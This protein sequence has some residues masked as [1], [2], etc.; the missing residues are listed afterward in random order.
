MSISIRTLKDEARFRSDRISL[1]LFNS[2]VEYK[3]IIAWALFYFYCRLSSQV[4]SREQPHS[5]HQTGFSFLAPLDS[6]LTHSGLADV[7]G[8]LDP[9]LVD[10][11]T[12]SASLSRD[13]HP[14]VASFIYD[15][16]SFW[17]Q[18]IES[19]FRSHFCCY[20][21]HV[22]RTYPLEHSDPASSFSWH[23]DEDPPALKKIFIY[24]DDT[25]RRNGAFRYFPKRPSRKLF[26]K[27]FISNS[28]SR[29]LKSQELIDPVM[30]RESTWAEGNAGQGFIFDNNIIHR[31]THPEAKHR[32]V[33]AIEVMPSSSPLTL[34]NI[35]NSLR[36]PIF[37][38]YPRKPWQNRYLIHTFQPP[39]C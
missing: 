37:D 16:L 19:I 7:I 2:S 20:W 5:F 39:P 28:V 6:S 13:S 3:T 21:I 29:R 32:T 11:G 38:D 10:N 1:L 12:G 31:G 22:Y 26:K 18:E 17:R 30:L 8:Y 23:Y 25:N 34:H 27:G 15:C 24:L 33:I 14:L 4:K 36:L 9:L 35:D